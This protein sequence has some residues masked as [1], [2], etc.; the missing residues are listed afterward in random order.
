MTPK[1][2]LDENSLVAELLRAKSFH[3]VCSPARCIDLVQG[4]LGRRSRECEGLAPPIFI[5]EPVPDLCLPT[6]LENCR[7]AL[8]LVDAVS[9]NHTEL[10]A[11]F[12]AKAER[13]DEVDRD[14]IR[15]LTTNF[16]STGVGKNGSGAVVVRSGKEGC[17]VAT[18]EVTKWFPAYHQPPSTKV[19]DPTGGGNGFLGGLAIALARGYDI[20]EAV[21]WGSISASFCIEQVGMPTLTQHTDGERWNGDKVQE[22]LAQFRTRLL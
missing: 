5:W 4:I 18:R 13:G 21:I 6:E 2:R 14:V 10:A 7:N 9:P 15:D 20:E 8:K 19:I 3:M 17:Y 12:G 11:F 16:L 1:V 22:R